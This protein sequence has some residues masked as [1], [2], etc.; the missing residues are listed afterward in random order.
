MDV[1][2]IHVH[3]EGRNRRLEEAIIGTIPKSRH[4]RGLINGVGS[5]IKFLFRNLDVSDG[6]EIQKQVNL[7]KER[8]QE[9]A[10]VIHNH[11]TILRTSLESIRTTAQVLDRNNR[12]V[13]ESIKRL[14][15][16]LPTLNESQESSSQFNV[17]VSLLL[18]Y[19]EELI[20]DL[21][22]FNS[23]FQIT[24]RSHYSIFTNEYVLQRIR[25][26]NNQLNMYVIYR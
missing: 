26:I 12:E 10:I 14:H 16:E 7:V 25:K 13:E 1:P 5:A 20:T 22:T 2:H 21:N 3:G 18:V 6:E 4:R 9:I 15:W 11:S 24:T 19:L 23:C 17:I 8:D